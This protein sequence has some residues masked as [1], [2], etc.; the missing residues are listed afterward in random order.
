MFREYGENAP[1]DVYEIIA[2]QIEDDMEDIRRE[3]EESEARLL[4]Y[5]AISASW[6]PLA[7][8]ITKNRLL[9]I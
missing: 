9:P 3:R 5:E 2:R 8:L 4:A 7:E 1:G 6:I